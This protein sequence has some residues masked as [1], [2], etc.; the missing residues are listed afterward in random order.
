MFREARVTSS[1]D[2]LWGVSTSAFQIEGAFTAAGRQPSVWDTFPAFG[3]QDASTACD[4]Y[5]RYR[6]DVA[7]MRSLGVGAYR[8]SVSWPR[9]LAGDLAFY[10][11]L[12]DE[13][14]EAGIAPVATLYHW[15]TPLHLE[16]AGGW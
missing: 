10:D 14:L 4:H 9:V 5:H 7:L 8:F 2:F 16:E 1:D 15:D 12:V 11:R 6:E 3:G 13:L